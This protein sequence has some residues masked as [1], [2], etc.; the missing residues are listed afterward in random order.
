MID[1]S[2]NLLISLVS[3]LSNASPVSFALYEFILA[4]D[5]VFDNCPQIPGNR[6]IHDLFDMANVTLVYSE[7]RV[8]IG[9]SGVCNWEGMQP[10]DRI[11][12]RAELL[13]YHR[14][15]WQPTPLSSATNNFCETLF[16]PT[17][18]TYHM[19]GRHIVESERK[20][21]SNY[22]APTGF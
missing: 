13:K 2:S 21:V 16:D 3:I 22:G 15:T 19:W 4:N 10:N 1:L 7:G 9:G 12:S 18:L 14:G 8:T 5:E 11:R 17:S 6:G 20:C